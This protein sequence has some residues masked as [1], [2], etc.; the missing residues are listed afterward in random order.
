M[1]SLFSK[2]RITSIKI[3]L[4][5]GCGN[6]TSIVSSE[7]EGLGISRVI[8]DLRIP[9]STPYDLFREVFY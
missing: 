3:F 8:L 6:G 5:L 1:G 2:G 9:S 4:Y 7:V